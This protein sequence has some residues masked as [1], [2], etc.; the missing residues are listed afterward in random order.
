MEDLIKPN[1]SHINLANKHINPNWKY[2]LNL[3]STEFPLRTNY[4]LARILSVFNGANDI[5]VLSNFQKDRILNRWIVKKSPKTNKETLIKTKLLKS[6]VPHNF[7]IVKGIT[8]CS[9]SRKFVEYVLTNHFANN[10]LQW[11][12]DTY[13]PDEW[14]WATLNFNTQFN[15]PGGYKGKQ[16]KHYQTNYLTSF[17]HYFEFTDAKVYTVTRTRFI[18]WKQKYNCK[19]KLRHNICIFSIEDIP[20]LTPRPEF[21]LNKFLLD[22]DPITFQCME[23]WITNKVSLNQTADVSSYCRLSF[24]KPYSVHPSCTNLY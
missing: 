12:R 7:T 22:Y 4:E 5:E 2:L 23:E 8:Y 1:Y 18:G 21:F 10:L 3:A 6:S 15:P 11:S 13:S 14:F 20:K 17:N 19:G 16:Y 24:V 9:F